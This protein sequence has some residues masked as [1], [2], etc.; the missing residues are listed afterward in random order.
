MALDALFS[1]D[2]DQKFADSVAGLTTGF[3]GLAEEIK[4]TDEKIKA[5]MERDAT[6]GN[7]GAPGMAP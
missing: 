2:D 3:R 6:G 4:Q 7:G 5:I 1:R